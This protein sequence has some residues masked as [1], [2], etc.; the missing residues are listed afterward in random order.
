MKIYFAASIRGGGIDPETCREMMRHL[1]GHGTVFTEHICEEAGGRDDRDPDAEI[2]ERDIRWL[3]E[4]DL[5][6]AEVST[7]S[8][9][10]GYEIGKAEEWGKRILCLYR[11]GSPWRLSAMIGGNRS[12][13]VREYR[14]LQEA[15][16]H[17]DEFLKSP[18]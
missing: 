9:G 8:L 10:V 14:E 4:A 15:F 7:P 6:V 2:Y 5:M 11:R 17:I 13:V 12:L 1:K 18:L 16:A 3:R